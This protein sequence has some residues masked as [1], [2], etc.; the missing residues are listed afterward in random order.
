[1]G[2]YFHVLL[3]TPEP[4][5][6]AGMRVLLPWMEINRVPDAFHLS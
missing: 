5:L 3:E 4:N 6:S 2:D 1:M